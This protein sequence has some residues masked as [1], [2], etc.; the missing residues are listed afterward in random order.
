MVKN[1]L[2]LLK[3]PIPNSNTFLAHLKVQRKAQ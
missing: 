2:K 1:I 3:M